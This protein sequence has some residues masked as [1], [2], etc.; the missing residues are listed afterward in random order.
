MKVQNHPD[1]PSGQALRIKQI[2]MIGA[3]TNANALYGRMN[4]KRA[5]FKLP[6]HEAY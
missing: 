2:L 6:Q 4:S 3:V 5:S 1:C